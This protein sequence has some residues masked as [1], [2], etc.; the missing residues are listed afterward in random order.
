VSDRNEV[1]TRDNDDDDA[2][3]DE[4]MATESDRCPSSWQLL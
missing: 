2:D 3:G 1:Q 4:K